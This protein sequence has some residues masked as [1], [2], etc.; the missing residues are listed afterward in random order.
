MTLS[1]LGLKPYNTKMSHTPAALLDEDTG[2]A[3]LS[4]NSTCIPREFLS[5][6]TLGA[7]VSQ[8]DHSKTIKILGSTSML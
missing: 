3:P 7:A 2:R 6:T 5:A 8:A 4:E 1:L